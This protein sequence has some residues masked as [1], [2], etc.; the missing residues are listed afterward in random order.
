MKKLLTIF[1]GLVMAVSVFGADQLS[2]RI[3]TE[4]PDL[5]ADGAPVLV[6][7]TYLVVY[8]PNGQL[9]QGVRTDRSLVDPD[10]NI[11]VTTR[12]AV[13]GY[14]CEYKPH[15]YP[16]TKYSGDGT[17]VIVLLDTRKADG[18]VGGSVAGYNLPTVSTA[19]DGMGT[20]NGGV[21]TAV[22]A[23]ETPVP[24][25]AKPTITELVK[26]GESA[27]IRFKDVTIGSDYDVEFSTNLAANVWISTKGKPTDRR[28]TATE[29][30]NVVKLNNVNVM[31]L[32]NVKAPSTEPVRFF[33]VVTP[34]S[35]KP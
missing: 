11:L 21:G 13:K 5:Y 19:A 28:V 1:A 18:S 15:Q 3:W 24:L 25:A 32:D 20:L 26:D 12:L 22:T 31:T 35:N 34:P 29:G 2:L 6:G 30:V 7:E 16:A 14:K 17:F 9:F 8:L 33:R 27:S 4:G 23:S 10:N